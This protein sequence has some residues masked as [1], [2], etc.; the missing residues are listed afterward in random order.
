MYLLIKKFTT[1]LKK[2]HILKDSI[3]NYCNSHFHYCIFLLFSIF[4]ILNAIN[5]SNYFIKS[6]KLTENQILYI[7]SSIAQVTGALLGLTIAGYGVI[8][9]KNRDI[10]IEDT[11]IT[12]FIN[13]LRHDYFISLINIIIYSISNI[14]SCLI[15]L[16]LY[17]KPCTNLSTFFMT[18]SV[19]LFLMIMIEIIKFVY[20][21]NPDAL[22]KIGSQNKDSIDREHISSNYSNEK[23]SPFITYYNLLEKLLKD[24]A[25]FLIGSPQSINKIQTNESLDILTQHNV[26]NRQSYY[27]INEL[28]KYR[29]A[30]VHSLDTD[31]SVNTKIY[32][33]LIEIYNTLKN[34]YDSREK[35]E[36]QGYKENYDHLIKYSNSRGFSEIDKQLI[37]YLENNPYSSI[38]EISKALSISRASVTHKIRYFQSLG[39]IE[40]HNGKKRWI[41]IQH[42]K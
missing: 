9:Q 36:S 32:D 17:N 15:T 42:S 25:C 35:T 39:I 8:D 22:K 21:I 1:Y 40:Y 29:N 41:I 26:I 4:T 10:G 6:I 33:E 34:M 11:T 3:K 37:D 14:L 31:K 16:A 18:E 20:Y 13:S 23:F 30:L 24:Y 12:D 28:R 38:N 19:I 27:I 2:L 5:S 7:Y